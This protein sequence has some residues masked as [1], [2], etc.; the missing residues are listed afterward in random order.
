MCKKMPTMNSFF[1]VNLQPLALK[2]CK[3]FEI[4][5]SI[6]HLPRECFWQKQSWCMDFVKLPEYL[7]L[8]M[9]V[10]GCFCWKYNPC[11]I[12]KFFP[13]QYLWIR[14]SLVFKNKHFPGISNKVSLLVLILGFILGDNIMTLNLFTNTFLENAENEVLV[15]L[16]LFFMYCGN[17]HTHLQFTFLP[18]LA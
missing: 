15:K 14:K 4:S 9:M 5:Y 10:N 6:D 16:E 18:K 13:F 3:I 1:L 12:K 2:F 8:K 11:L 17:L 7:F